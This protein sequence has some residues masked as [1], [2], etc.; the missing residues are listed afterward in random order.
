MS[1]VKKKN[2]NFLITLNQ[3]ENFDK[4]KEYLQHFK[5][6]QYAIAT[7]EKAPTTGHEH[8]HIYCQFGNAISLS[9]EKLCRAHID[10]CFGSAQQNID[11]IKKK[12]EPEKRGI[13][14]W[15]EGT[16]KF[17]GGVSI[18][19]VKS[20]SQEERGALP[21]AYF[22]A[23]EKL[24]ANE[25]VHINLNEM[26]KQVDVR[27]IFG[28]SG[29]GK[30]TLAIKWLNELGATNADS[31]CYVNGFWNGVSDTCDYAIYD[32]FRD[33]DLPAVEFIKFID[34]TIKILNVKG[35]YI[36]NR[37]KYIFIT[38]IQDPSSM[39]GKEFEE[40][41]QWLRRMKI[42]QF[43]NPKDYQEVKYND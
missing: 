7:K 27:F 18:N 41:K 17:R 2:R 20:M 1:E 32:D 15:E 25:N 37:Y 16:P 34:Y 35:N 23:V 30:T 42:Y 31:V 38:S 9:P 13:I 5:T 43:N 33:S 26:F 12:K 36:K 6:F 11:Y 22:K 40:A 29:Y 4:I 19:E 3:V 14:I 10:Q 21:F 39:F 8:I 28:K 24:N